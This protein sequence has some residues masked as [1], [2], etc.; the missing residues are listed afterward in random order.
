MLDAEGRMVT[1][2]QKNV[3]SLKLNDCD[4]PCQKKFV[5]CTVYSWVTHL[6]FS[7]CSLDRDKSKQVEKVSF[8]CVSPHLIVCDTD[9]VWI[10]IS[11]CH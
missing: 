10:K 11:V 1:D 8:L 2:F 9:C 7:R 6:S 5:F 3:M 4:I